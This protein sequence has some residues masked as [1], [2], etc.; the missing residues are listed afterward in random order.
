MNKWNKVGVSFGHDYHEYDDIALAGRRL[1]ELYA[2]GIRRVRINMPAYTTEANNTAF[3]DKLR[4]LV[5]TALD[6]GFYVI[7]GYT[8]SQDQTVPLLSAATWPDYSTAVQAMATW[9]QSLP[10]SQNFE[11]SLG[12]EDDDKVDGTTLTSAQFRDNILTLATTC[13]SIFTK[14]K[15]SYTSTIAYYNDWKVLGIGDMDYYGCNIYASA[16]I[17]DTYAQGIARDWGDRGYIPEWNAA[18]EGVNSF[19]TEDAYNR[20]MLRRFQLLR[21]LNVGNYFFVSRSWGVAEKWAL[22]KMDETKRQTWYFLTSSRLPIY[23]TSPKQNPGTNYVINPSFDASVANWTTENST[24]TRMTSGGG[25][26]TAAYARLTTSANSA[27]RVNIQHLSGMRF[28]GKRCVISWYARAGTSSNMYIEAII[29]G[30]A[31][32]IQSFALTDTWTRY[33]VSFIVANSGSG[34]T[35]YFYPKQQG[36]STVGSVDI[37][38]VQMEF[39]D[40]SIPATSYPTDYM[41]GSIASV[42]WSGTA[43]ASSS[44]RYTIPARHAA[45][46]RQT[47]G[48]RSPALNRQSA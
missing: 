28:W 8:K 35:I 34:G 10:N 17:F 13:K 45:P 24:F 40:Q 44:T 32:Q 15:I 43:N 29:G 38:N 25:A 42:R 20:E 7:W 21:R 47:A 3:R 33:S 5:T 9:A 6:K 46:T 23:S 41:D 19:S 22:I 16:S 48:A 36:T 27:G 11:L 30:T 26:L 31:T 1:D 12:N 14:G 39:L 37:S 2:A 4:A 18:D